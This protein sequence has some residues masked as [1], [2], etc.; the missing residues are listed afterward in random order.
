M[1]F[2]VVY[3]Y[4]GV[5]FFYCDVYW[6]LWYNENFFL[7]GFVKDFFGESMDFVKMFMWDFFYMVNEYWLDVY[8][9]DGFCYDCV[10]NYWD[11]LMGVGYVKFI[12]MVY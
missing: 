8:Y 1:I 6:W 7:G 4:I 2:D 11:G 10:L 3:G 12:Y 9:F 5:E